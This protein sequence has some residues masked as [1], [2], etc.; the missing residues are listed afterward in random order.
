MASVPA[1]MVV[2][3][4]NVFTPER[5]N[6]PEACFTRLILPPPMIPANVDEAFP[7][8]FPTVSVAVPVELMTFPPATPPPLNAAN[9]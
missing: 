5:V 3:P 7:V 6:V 1:L 2:V 9:V 8:V 4:V